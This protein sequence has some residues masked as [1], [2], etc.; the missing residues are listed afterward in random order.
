MR[1]GK[2]LDRD[3]VHLQF[4]CR[5]RFCDKRMDRGHEFELLRKDDRP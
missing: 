2:Y 4:V 3:F 1:C 5:N